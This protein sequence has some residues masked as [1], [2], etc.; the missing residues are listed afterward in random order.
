MKRTKGIYLGLLAVLLSPMAANADPIT[1]DFEWTGSGG[2][3]MVG[4]FTYDDV[5]AADGAV[6]DGEV[7]SLF[8]EGFFN[9]VSFATNSTAHLLSGFNFNFD[10][11]AG[12]FFLNGVSSGD[13][14]QLWNITGTGFGFAA[15]SGASGLTLDGEVLG[16]INNPVPMTATVASVPEPGTMALFGI[17]LAGMGLARR[18]R[19]A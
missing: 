6:R 2:Y 19:K 4:N 11:V 10:P 3:S 17:G 7:S 18:R 16:L 15:G 12:Q 1:Y 9:G 14:G 13:S 5:D 8:F